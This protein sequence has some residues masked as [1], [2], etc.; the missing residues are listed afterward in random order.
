MERNATKIREVMSP[1]EYL[2]NTFGT[3]LTVVI[4]IIFGA[5]IPFKIIN[6]QSHTVFAEIGN[7]RFIG[8]A[9]ILI[10]AIGYL[11]CCWK[12]ILDA[13]GIPAMEGMQ[14]HLIVKGVYKYVRN[15]IYISFWLIILGEAIYFQ[16]QD[17]LLYLL[18]WMVVFQIRVVFFEEPYLKV[19]FGESYESY[20]KSVPRWIPRLRGYCV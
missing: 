5:F 12:F 14:K 13:K 16:S 2:A 18:G 8:P 6:S 11:A 20:C 7:L 4:A 15:P 10:G 9:F 19:T 3:V 17:L 1:K